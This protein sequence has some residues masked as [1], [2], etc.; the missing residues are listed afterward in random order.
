M[1]CPCC[2]MMP[3]SL[4]C[5]PLL[6]GARPA[7]S[8]LALMRSRYTAFA[9][10]NAQYLYDT[11]AKSERGQNRLADIARGLEGS[12]WVKLEIVAVH[13]VD[14]NHARVS[15][16]AYQQKGNQQYCLAEDSAFQ[17]EEEGW[18][19]VQKRSKPLAD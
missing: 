12:M 6:S 11:Y 3:Y 16:R 7:S 13:Q 15:F 9:M 14:A 4:C 5:A 8:A 10:K 17:K 19:Y 18:R 2:S 1:K